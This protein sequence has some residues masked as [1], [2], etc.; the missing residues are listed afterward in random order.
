[1]KWIIGELHFWRNSMTLKEIQKKIKLSAVDAYIVSYGNKFI[2]QDV[3]LKEH[4]IFSLCGFDGSAGAMM[5]TENDAYL[6]VD[7][8]YELQAKQ[9]V[10]TDIVKI[11]DKSPRVKNI[12]EEAVKLNI[13]KIGY[14][15]WNYSVSEMEY[16]KRKYRDIDFM[17]VGDWI[18]LPINNAVEVLMRD[19]KFSGISTEEKCKVVANMLWEQHAD[20][21]LFTSA[22]SVSWLLNIYA[23]D[24]EFSPVVR[25]YALLSLK[26]EVTLFGDVKVEG[27]ECKSFNELSTTLNELGGARILY[28]AHF[29]PEKI[30]LLGI[31]ELIF[32]KSSDIIQIMKAEKNETELQGMVN[33]HIRDGVALVK[34]LCWLDNNYKGKNELDVVKILHE[35]RQQQDL[36]FS[37]SFGTIAGAGK[38][39]AVVH[40]HPT[41]T[42]FSLLQENNL[43]LLDSGAQYLDGTTD[44]TRTIALGIPSKDMIDDFTCVLKAHISLAKSRFPIN[45]SGGILDVLARVNI[46]NK[47]LNYNHGTGHGVACFGNVHEGPVS[48][49]PNASH[50]GLKEN[51]V[52]SIEPG[53]YKEAEYGIRIENLVYTSKVE[54][55]GKNC[56]FL[57]FKY[58]TKVPIDKKLIDK[59]LLNEDELAWLNEY[60]KN[61]Y[62]SLVPFLNKTEQCWLEKACSPL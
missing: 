39:G 49:S 4:K 23:R 60:H 30:K 7:G 50:Y 42:N 3:L 54:N 17:D 9:Q 16:I 31:E 51:M 5:I 15:A 28:D 61:V 37:E 14:D 8:R 18:N 26:G 11:I 29:T 12:C 47:C 20:Y 62:E 44:V 32:E 2:G 56:E 1:M 55:D 38:N 34:F 10:N 24:L 33:S 59:Y 53:I 27:I 48:I 46:W 41:E 13:K 58:L 52:L 40:Y 57:E 19:V 21:F 36:F 43:L 45:T 22:D 25:A 35:Y 6:F